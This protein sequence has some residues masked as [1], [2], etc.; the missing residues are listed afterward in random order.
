MNRIL[1][2]HI[3][4]YGCLHRVRE[5]VF[6]LKMNK[7]IEKTVAGCRWCATIQRKQ[8]KELLIPHEISDVPWQRVACD[9]FVHNNV[10]YLLTVDYHSHFFEADCFMDKKAPEVIRHLRAHSARYG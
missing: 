9:L 6:W 4:F 10:D 1:S 5:A 7:V 2:S 3:G 8:A